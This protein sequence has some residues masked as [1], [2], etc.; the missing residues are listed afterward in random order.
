[1]PNEELR[2]PPKT[3]ALEDVLTLGINSLVD[4]RPVTLTNKI[5][6]L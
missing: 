2:E 3:S 6:A 4:F 1:M 5:K